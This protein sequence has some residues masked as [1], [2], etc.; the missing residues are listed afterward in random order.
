MKPTKKALSCL[1]ALILCMT[2]LLAPIG[3][4]AAEDALTITSSTSGYRSF[5][6]PMT[7][8][9]STARWSHVMFSYQYQ[10]SD[11]QFVTINLAGDENKNAVISFDTYDSRTYK[12]ISTK[13]V[14]YELS[15]WCGAHFDGTYFYLAF[16]NSDNADYDDNREMLRIVKYDKNLKRIDAASSDGCYTYDICDAGSLRMDSLNDK[17][18]VYTCRERFD[19]HQ[20]NLLLYIDTDTMDILNTDTGAFPGCHVSH[21]FNQF[22]RFSSDGKAYLCDLGDAYPRAVSLQYCDTTTLDDG[23]F[24]CNI[25]PDLFEIPGETGANCTGVTLGGFELSETAGTA[26][27]AINTID[28]SKVTSYT[29]FDMYGLGRDERDAV[30]LVSNLATGKVKTV[31][32][33]DYVDKG[34]LAS[35][36]YLVKISEN[37]FLYLWEAFQYT[38]YSSAKSVGVRYIYVDGNGKALTGITKLPDARLSCSD[39]PTLIG[40]EVVWYLNSD[41]EK[42]RTFYRIDTTADMLKQQISVSMPTSVTYGDDSFK[43]SVTAD[44]SSGLKNFT[45]KSDN[46]AVATVSADGCVTIVGAGTTNITVMEPG[47]STYMESIVTKKLTVNKA[48]INITADNQIKKTGTADPVLTYTYSGEI[49]DGAVFTGSLSRKEGEEPGSYTITRGTL[50]L[51]DNYRLVMNSAVLAIVDEIKAPVIS[52]A[53]DVLPDACV[54]EKY[55]VTLT[56]DIPLPNT[57]TLA[58]GMLPAGMTFEN[59]TLSGTPEYESTVTLT[60]RADNGLTDAGTKSYTFRAHTFGETQTVTAATCTKAGTGIRT[61]TTCGAQQ[62]VELKALGTAKN[63]FA[64]CLSGRFGDVRY[65]DWFHEA[66]DYALS[67]GIMN[68][69]GDTTFTPNAKISR[70]M[71]AQVLYNR[72]GRPAVDT[73]ALYM[74][75]TADDW[76]Y[77]AMRWATANG[78]ILDTDGDGLIVPNGEITREEI[79]LILWRY[80]G[81]PNST[82]SLD[83]F[84]DTASISPDALTACRWAV[85]VG[86][87]RGNDEAKLNP[88]NTAMRSEA[89]QI[90]MNLFTKL[91]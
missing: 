56:T 86:I 42:T 61:C 19:G 11:T 60:F 55:S 72:A 18:V 87:Y 15:L 41:T 78:Y 91:G 49:S 33:S 17:L 69:T 5:G 66:V 9:L 59:G 1:L 73:D 65:G 77:D 10:I 23:W 25:L 26:L 32:F 31:Y 43:I 16:G 80:A 21:S 76:F 40:D 27:A 79:A 52:P 89:A 37:R 83:A 85:E 36:P 30:L 28:H 24:G 90:F 68:G 14:P 35:T 39:E 84:V 88:Q 20:S 13:N 4:Q 64:D 62:T 67:M 8:S 51:G 54:G 29:S 50:S 3:V 2:S 45:Y 57:W 70:A 71:L 48:R 22:V 47:S 34:M 12:R 75:I 44:K 6:F 46:E 82:Q 81:S 38:S 58:S 74:D 7:A 63:P 53:S